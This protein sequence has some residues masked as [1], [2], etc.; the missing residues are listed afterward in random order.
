MGG[1]HTRA[2]SVSAF[3]LSRVTSFPCALSRVVLALCSFV[4]AVL[5]IDPGFVVKKH[6]PGFLFE[7]GAWMARVPCIF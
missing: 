3:G 6:V 1:H 4:A 5:S 2:L 7:S